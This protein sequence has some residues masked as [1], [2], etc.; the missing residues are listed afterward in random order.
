MKPLYFL[1]FVL[2][3]CSCR[4]ENTL[5]CFRP[6]GP[7]VTET[8]K[9]GPFFH[10]TVY[11][12]M[13][14]FIRQGPSFEVKVTSGKNIISDIITEVRDSTLVL[15]NLNI[16]NF[17]RG[18]RRR[19]AVSITTPNVTRV[20][21]NGVGPVWL[22]PGLTQEFIRIRTESSGDVHIKGTYTTIETSAHGNGDIYLEG[23]SKNLFIYTYGT[24][25]LYGQKMAVDDY[26]F[27]STESLGDILLDCTRLGQLDYIINSSGNIVYTGNPAIIR[28]LGKSKTATG[29]L[30]QD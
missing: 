5:D 10:V 8:R 3:L 17:V 18:Y 15:E 21:N 14:V 30:I 12:N 25:Y 26:M 23:F 2:L 1:P 6:N 29:R 22:E 20:T 24:N 11:D 13:D 9:T 28:N 16:C 7:T 27:V 4:K 19:T